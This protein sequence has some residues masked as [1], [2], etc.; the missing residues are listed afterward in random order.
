VPSL[1]HNKYL[2]TLLWYLYPIQKKSSLFLAC[3]YESL[4]C[5]RKFWYRVGD[6]WYIL[7]AGLNFCVKIYT[8]NGWWKDTKWLGSYTINA[9]LVS[10][11]NNAQHR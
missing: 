10:N 8:I 3:F 7:R 9:F 2:F 5:W 4:E 11:D 1:I 6:I